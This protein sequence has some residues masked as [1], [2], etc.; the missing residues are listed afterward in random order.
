MLKPSH[1]PTLLLLTSSFPSSPT[2]ETCG[3][4]RDFARSLASEFKIEVLAPGS[5]GVSPACVGMVGA[6]PAGTRGA[7]APGDDWAPGETFTLRRAWSVLPRPLDPFTADSDLNHIVA[8]GLVI[9]LATV[10]SLVCFFLRAVV[11]SL[12]ADVVCS[13]W[14]LPC[15]LMGALISRM[16]G[17][18]HIVVE[19]SGGV[20]L[21]RRMRG[22]RGIARVIVSSCD[23]VITV[24]SDLKRKLVSLC[25]EAAFKTQVI[26]MGVNAAET[27]S[28]GSLIPPL[29]AIERSGN[30]ILF[31]GRLTEIKGLDV[32]LKAISGLAGIQLIVAGDGE[33]RDE[34]ERMSRDFSVD[35]VFLGRISAAERQMLLADCDAVV[36]PSRRLAGGRTEGTPLV[37]LEAMA[38]GRLVV[39][40]RAGGLAEVVEDGR[41][42]LLF[43]ESDHRMLR[44]KLMLGL[45]DDSLRR[46]IAQNARRSAEAYD[47]S[48]VA[49]RFIRIINESLKNGSVTDGQRSAARNIR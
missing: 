21:L 14:M 11:L 49:A 26:S 45:G 30:T 20:H 16:A 48:A 40:S 46:R 13:H 36:I 18:P 24:S 3:Y 6:A 15:G 10:V 8:R 22:G 43:D 2:D 4:I 29:G 47:W 28:R 9:R 42:G 33:L 38:A 12:R 39:A 1:K 17:K 5:A 32:L 31:I 25:P 44:E 37:C 7:S 35:A 19:H 41:N 23:R 34:Y 27:T